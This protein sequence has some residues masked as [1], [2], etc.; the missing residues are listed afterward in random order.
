[1]TALRKALFVE[2]APVAAAVVARAPKLYVVPTKAPAEAAPEAA[3]GTLKNIA[4][5]L[6]APFLGLAYIIALPVVGVGFLV[7]LAARAA[8]SMPMCFNAAATVRTAAY[9]AAPFIGLAYVVFFPVICLGLLVWT[10]GRALVG[11]EMR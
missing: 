11:T 7:V 6:A 5:F 3:G 8:S 2:E 10:G 9:L 1:M 4:L